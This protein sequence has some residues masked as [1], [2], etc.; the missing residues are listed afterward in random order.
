MDL[1]L[2]TD[3]DRFRQEICDLLSSEPVRAAIEDIR[4]R[5]SVDEPGMLDIYRELGSRGLLAVHWPTEYGGRGRSLVEK[6][7]L[8]EELILHGVPDIVHTSS[9]DY[10]GQALLTFG[11][12]G[13]KERLLPGLARGEQSASVLLSERGAGSD[14][15]S[16]TTR[17][18]PDGDGWRLH[19]H[20]IYNMKSHVADI[21]LCA[22]RTTESSVKCHGITLF[23][24]PMKT[25]GVIVE[26]LW[27]LSNDRYCDVT[28]GG[29]QVRAD[30]VLGAVDEGWQVINKILGIE[31][32]GIEYEAKG[33]KALD[34]IMR[35]ARQTGQL[36]NAAYGQQLIKL[37]AQARAGR[38]LAWRAVT[39]LLY[40]D[41]DAVGSAMA[42]WYVTEVGKSIVGHGTEIMGLGSVLT[43][44]DADAPLGGSIES[45]YREAPGWTLAGG[46]SE[47]MLN[48]IA[49]T[50]LELL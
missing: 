48:I 4:L 45:A 49:S 32:A 47:I 1:G 50:G 6:S 27:C 37:D 5:S 3:Q 10:V 25:P 18:E 16:L 33:R 38:L 30:N 20:K 44:L 23:I 13:Q 29:I 43:S 42:K 12:Q 17:A 19:G 28:L 7:I 39:N 9:I 14:L 21:A 40:G 34:V 41:A 8:T 35:H 26:P 2:T 24:V 31:R 15:A 36:S 22:A 11:T 46:A